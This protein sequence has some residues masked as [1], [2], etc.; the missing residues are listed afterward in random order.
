MNVQNHTDQVVAIRVRGTEDFA[1]ED[2]AGQMAFGPLCARTLFFDPVSDFE[3]ITA[4]KSAAPGGHDSVQQIA[5][6]RTLA[7]VV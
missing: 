5:F 6:T 3:A 4:H 1:Y 7:R 2:D